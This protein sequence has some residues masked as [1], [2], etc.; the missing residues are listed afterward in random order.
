MYVSIVT[1]AIVASNYGF[2]STTFTHQARQKYHLV[3][4]IFKA[5]Q[6]MISQVIL[7]VR[8]MLPNR[9]WVATS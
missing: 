3:P 9:S 7:G 8:Y 2:F 6:T 4:P 1:I 5:I